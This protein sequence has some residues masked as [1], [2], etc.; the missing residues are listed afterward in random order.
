MPGPTD[1]ARPDRPIVKAKLAVIAALSVERTL[2]DRERQGFSLIQSGPGAESAGRAATQALESGAEALLSW[3]LAGALEPSVPPGTVLLP[4]RVRGADGQDF[5]ADDA[6]HA[7]L[8]TALS[9][10]FGVSSGTLVSVGSVLEGPKDKTKAALRYE[11]VACDMESAAIARIAH[12]AGVPFVALRVVADGLWDRLPAGIGQWVD[13]AGNRLVW[14]LL[15]ASLHPA[16]WQPLWLISR[17]FRRA[18]R[19]LAAVAQSLARRE[20]LLGSVQGSAA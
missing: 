6:W 20:F 17:R 8:A 16:Q 1:L 14:P 19:S 9:D 15:T 4:R 2:L 3:G 11:A 10:R 5:S 13:S 18:R 7:A 12:E